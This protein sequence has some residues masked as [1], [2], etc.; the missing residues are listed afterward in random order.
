MDNLNRRK[1]DPVQQQIEELILTATDPKDKAFLLIMNKIAVSLDMNTKLTVELSEELKS[2]TK[3]F[4]T[5]EIQESALI[6]QGKGGI[7]VAVILLAVIQA[8]ALFV[9]GSAFNDLTKV[10]ED[11]ISINSKV[12]IHQEQIRILQSH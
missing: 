5:H 4:K 11:I 1:G 12:L 9:V 10:K 6:N 2:H 7:R 3:A 8:L